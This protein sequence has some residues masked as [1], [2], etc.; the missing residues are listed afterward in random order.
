MGLHCYT[1]M[2]TVATQMCYDVNLYVHCQSS[3]VVYFFG[4]SF[5]IL[6]LHVVMVWS[7][8]VHVSIKKNR[9]GLSPW[10]TFLAAAFPSVI[11]DT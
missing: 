8:L 3:L 9:Q 2:A 10:D 1:S 7:K 11:T 5:N 4:I 6:P